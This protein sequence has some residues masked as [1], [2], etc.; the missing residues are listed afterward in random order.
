MFRALINS[1]NNFSI[2]NSGN[3]VEKQCKNS[4]QAIYS[5]VLPSS[6]MVF[7]DALASLDFKLSVSQGCFS[8]SASSGLLELFFHTFQ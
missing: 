4:V 3:S 5:A 2:S 7:L 6:L 8:A 1:V